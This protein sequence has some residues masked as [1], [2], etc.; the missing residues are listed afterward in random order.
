MSASHLLFSKPKTDQTTSSSPLVEAKLESVS[1]PISKK[2]KC[3][4]PM[5]LVKRVALRAAIATQVE[6][7][8]RYGLLNGLTEKRM[9]FILKQPNIDGIIKT[10][11]SARCELMT[12]SADFPGL[13]ERLRKRIN[14]KYEELNKLISKYT[15]EIIENT[16]FELVDKVVAENKSGFFAAFKEPRERKKKGIFV[17]NKSISLKR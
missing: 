6:R 7:N 12:L 14:K 3:L 13:K 2:T 9:V 4:Q 10:I 8:L 1:E 5:S 15:D 17:F 11:A 16:M